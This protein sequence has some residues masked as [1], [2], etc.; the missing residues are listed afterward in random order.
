MKE[1]ENT[2]RDILLAG[3]A[4]LIIGSKGSYGARS[5]ADDKVGKRAEPCQV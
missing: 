2:R 1:R 4:L 5:I 3:E